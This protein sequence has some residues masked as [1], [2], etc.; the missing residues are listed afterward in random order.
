MRYTFR[1]RRVPVLHR[2][3]AREIL[4]GKTKISL[5]LGLS[6]EKIERERDGALIRG[7]FVKGE[8]IEKI[9]RDRQSNLF[10]VFPGR[11][12]KALFFEKSVYKLRLISPTTAPTL[13]INGIHMHR[14]KGITPWRDA[15]EKVLALKVSSGERVLD[16]CTGLGYTAIHAFL[17]GAEV[18]TVE[19]D[20]NV[21]FL[22][23]HNPWSSTLERIEIHLKDAF[24]LLEKFSSCSF[25]AVLHDPPREALARELY[26]RKF[27]RKIFR[28]LKPGGR[29]L[30]YAGNPKK[31]SCNLLVH[32]EKRLRDAGFA[33]TEILEDIFC[34]YAEKR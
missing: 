27:Y 19:K 22:A 13:E 14:I 28:I 2:Y 24:T 15:E 31:G 12:A 6:R 34:V 1:Y 4:N 9:S 30:H 10:F 20:G 11:V 18:V 7:I 29:L 16:L 23:E 5:D 17:R 3:N 26:S 8:I 21:L 32:V 25:H 33:N